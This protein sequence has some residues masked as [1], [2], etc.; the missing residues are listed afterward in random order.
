MQTKPSPRKR[1]QTC[2]PTFV[3][4]DKLGTL[5]S[6]SQKVKTTI[7]QPQSSFNVSDRRK[8]EVGVPTFDVNDID[9]LGDRLAVRITDSQ[10]PYYRSSQLHNYASDLAAQLDLSDEND[11]VSQRSKSPETDLSRTDSSQKKS[12]K[13]NSSKSNSPNPHM[14]LKTDLKRPKSPSQQVG[15]PKAFRLKSEPPNQA[16]TALPTNLQRSPRTSRPASASPAIGPRKTL[17]TRQG[18]SQFDRLRELIPPPLPTEY[19]GRNLTLGVN[20]STMKRSITPET[21]EY[22]CVD[23]IDLTTRPATA[24]QD[25]PELTIPEIE[26]RDISLI[27]TRDS[28]DF[29]FPWSR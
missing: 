14:P 21:P 15:L 20:A 4:A 22:E 2:L 16:Q 8:H 5:K 23:G 6:Q 10:L 27:E 7:R 11:S 13:T 3:E 28:E 9:V 25:E 29:Q 17:D 18:R 24:K 26:A 12:S 19:L 1:Y